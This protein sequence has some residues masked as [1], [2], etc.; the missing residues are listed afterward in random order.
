MNAK[1]AKV[2]R[3]EARKKLNGFLETL[4]DLPLRYRLKVAWKILKGR[5]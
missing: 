4:L 5:H 3:K 1:R 2:L